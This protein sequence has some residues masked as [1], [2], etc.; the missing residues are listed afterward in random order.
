MSLDF[1]ETYKRTGPPPCFSPDG[2]KI[3]TAV[4]HRLVLR[5]AETC[6]VICM[7][8]CVD[9]IQHIEWSHDS[10]HV[11]CAV[12]RKGKVQVFKFS[13]DEWKAL[14]D[15]GPAG[16]AFAKWAPCGTKVSDKI[17][18][19]FSMSF[20]VPEFPVFVTSCEGFLAIPI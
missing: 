2:Q 14:I 7:Q 18:L 19:A 9:K 13:D 3:A 5:D 6:A 15:E 10:D 1:S 17:L 4:D 11:L 16:I 8:E 12:Y 20:R